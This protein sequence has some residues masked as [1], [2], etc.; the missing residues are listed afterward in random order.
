VVVLAGEPDL[1]GH[2]TDVGKPIDGLGITRTIVNIP[3]I[4]YIYHL[5]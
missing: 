1:S 4:A 2:V 5:S 3:A